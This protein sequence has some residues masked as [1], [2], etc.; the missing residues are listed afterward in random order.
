MNREIT[1][2]RSN[3]IMMYARG[4]NTQLNIGLK[5][6]PKYGLGCTTNVRI[7]TSVTNALNWNYCPEAIGLLELH[8]P[9]N[10]VHLLVFWLETT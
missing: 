1:F 2:D 7:A 8:N 9:S 6:H 10:T 4:K 3:D 5:V